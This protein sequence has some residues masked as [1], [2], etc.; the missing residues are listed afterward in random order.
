MASARNKARIQ[1]ALLVWARHTARY[2]VDEAAN[3]ASVK[4]GQIEA[5]EAGRD[6]PT[7][8]QLRKLAQVYK[9]PLVVFYLPEP[10]KDFDAMRDFRRLRPGQPT[11][12]PQLAAEIRWAHEMREVAREAHAA[13][14]AE[15]A[16]F[17]LTADLAEPA[18]VVAARAR[19]SLGVEIEPQFAWKNNREALN[20]WRASLERL[21]ILCFQFTGVEV[22]EARAFSIH[23]AEFPV[24]AVNAGDAV[25]G[26]V[27]SLAHELTHL[28]LG[29]SA[30]CDLHEA[31]VGTSTD[32]IEAFCNAVAGELL[33]PASS[34]GAQPEIR[35]SAG[36][37][38]WDNRTIN[39]LATRFKVSPEVI[40]RRLLTLGL[41]SESFYR[42]KREEFA[43]AS[44]QERKS[45]GGDYYRNLKTKLGVPLIRAV[46][47]AYHLRTLTANEAAA[48]LRVK[49]DALPRLVD[50]VVQVA[51]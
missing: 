33:V 17:G 48:Y 35:R 6:Q 23:Q 4:P 24:V 50:A 44:E 8:A 43:V 3:A 36:P 30:T 18:A 16:H 25:A 21:G 22:T 12:S 19:A 47:D 32:R 1:P 14:G 28:M 37:R 41:V 13:S 20:G 51:S 42:K 10:P 31:G 49:V 5:W 45:G 15:Y 38:A 2:S 9:R 11:E 40:A 29:G 26:R 27:F 39:V 7:I 34:L 46:L